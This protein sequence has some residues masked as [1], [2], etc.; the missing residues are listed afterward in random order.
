MDT[1]TYPD[2]AVRE[3]ARPFVCIRVEHDRS[4]ELVKQYGVKGLPDVRLLDPEGRETSRLRGFTSAQK[5]AAALRGGA[6]ADT[7]KA[8]VREVPVTPG[9]V[10]EAVK[11]G[12]AFLQASDPKGAE[13]LVLFALAAS[14]APIPEERLKRALAIPLSGT[15]QAAFRALALL[16]L[17]RKDAL[18]D[19]AAFLLHTQL[20]N[21]QWTYGPPAAG[22]APPALGDHS[23]SAYGL[24]GLAACRHA[25]IVVPH[26]ALEKAEGAWRKSQNPD[27][28]WGYRTDRETESYAS[29]TESALSS[30]LLCGGRPEK[31]LG[32]L[33]KHVSATENLGSPYPQGRLLYHLYALERLGTLLGSGK[34]GGHDWY[35]EG[36]A[37]LLGTQRPD[38]SWD[39]GADLPVPNTAFAI[40]FLSRSTQPLQA[41][42][43]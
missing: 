32:W 31:D 6:A 12:A 13:D 16:K 36:A 14:G 15:Y 5:L 27:G 22:Q 10:A 9:A 24:L 23:N 43:R 30:L 4:P 7:P 33:E 34:L 2:S 42:A 38:G 35:R 41:L 37:F 26:A 19:C 25:G 17:D 21:G 18:K 29:M 3:A 20:A 40:L 1:V 11:K 28:G 39:D 8:E